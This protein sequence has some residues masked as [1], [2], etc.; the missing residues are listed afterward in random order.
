VYLVRCA[1]FDQHARTCT[2]YDD[3]PPICSGYPWYDDA[4][5]PGRYSLDPVCAF[6]ADVRTVLPLTVVN[7]ERCC[8]SHGRNC[9][10]PSELC[11]YSCPEAGH[12]MGD[13]LRGVHTDG[14]LCASP[15][16]SGTSVHGR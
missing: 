11:C 13:S 2:A 9:E 7:R 15:D 3:R 5:D 12:R 6:H 14:S 4:P 10:P 16:L 8:D 1:K